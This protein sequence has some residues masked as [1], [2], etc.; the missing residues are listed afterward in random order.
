MNRHVEVKYRKFPVAFGQRLVDTPA[1]A[2]WKQAGWCITWKHRTIE[3][4]DVIIETLLKRTA[5]GSVLIES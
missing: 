1:F 3:R 5:Q 4:G 2:P